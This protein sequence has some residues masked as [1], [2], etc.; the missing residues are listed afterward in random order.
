MFRA[1]GGLALIVDH[2][3]QRLGLG[4]P[5]LAMQRLSQRL[6]R[7]QRLRVIGAQTLGLTRH[8]LAQKRLG[9]RE[10]T[11]EELCES[12]VVART[13][14]FFRRFARQRRAVAGQ[15]LI[16]QIDGGLGF[17]LGLHHLGLG[18]AYLIRRQTGIQSGL[19]HVSQQAI[20]GR[21]RG[22]RIT[23]LAQLDGSH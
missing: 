6:D 2:A 10:I 17:A 1:I 7:V 19:L 4:Q 11:Q 21:Q 18:Q 20:E 3:I 14:V 22:I 16:D 8:D 12:Q 9:G 23:A 13:V 5:A 15:Y